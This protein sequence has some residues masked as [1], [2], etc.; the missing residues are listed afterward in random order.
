MRYLV[1]GGAG[2]IGSHLVEKRVSLGSEV[3]V[4]DNLSTGFIE[5]IE[6]YLD[7][8]EFVDGDIRDL[9]TCHAV[10]EALT[11][12]FI[13]QRSAQSLVPSTTPSLHMRSTR[14]EPSM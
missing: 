1:T 7:R 2:F 8:I 9:D 4:L 14:P 5:N 11:T 12:F 10:C 3:V 6:P 13:K